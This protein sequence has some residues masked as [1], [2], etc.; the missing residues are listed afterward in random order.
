MFA[1]ERAR[2]MIEIVVKDG[3]YIVTLPK[4]ILLLTKEEFIQAL[5]RGTWWNRRAA[6]EAR[7]SRTPRR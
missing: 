7:L 5:R 3:W 4:S 2:D 6:I 1:E